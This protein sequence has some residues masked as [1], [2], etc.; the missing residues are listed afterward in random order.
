MQG[1]RQCPCAAGRKS[2]RY[3]RANVRLIDEQQIY[4][5]HSTNLGQQTAGSAMKRWFFGVGLAELCMPS[6]YLMSNEAKI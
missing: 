6:M 4:P 1:I 5:G 2:L 3:L